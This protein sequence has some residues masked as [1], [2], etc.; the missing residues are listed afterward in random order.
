MA[1]PSYHSQPNAAFQP[2]KS[3]PKKPKRI[4]TPAKTTGMGRDQLKRPKTHTT[5]KV[6]KQA[7][8][9]PAYTPPGDKRPKPKV[10]SKI[11][12]WYKQNSKTGKISGKTPGW[13]RNGRGPVGK[14]AFTKANRPRG[15][16]SGGSGGGAGGGGGGAGGSTPP[17]S[18]GP[19]ASTAPSAAAA[20]ADDSKFWDDVFGP[21]QREIERQ[22]NLMLEQK[23]QSQAA[24]DSYGKWAEDKR[25]QTAGL[26]TTSQQEQQ[27]AYDTARQQ[28][29]QQIKSYVDMAR[30][31]TGAPPQG[32]DIAQA[33]GT[34][35]LADKAAANNAIG[36]VNADFL[37]S[38][39]ARMQQ[40]MADQQGVN[41]AFVKGTMLE[42][43]YA[44]GKASEALAR[45]A[46][47][48]EQAKGTAKL[49]KF[50]RDRQ[51]GLDR[52]TLDW[53]KSLQGGQLALEQQKVALS[54]QG[55]ALKAQIDAQKLNAQE[56]QRAIDNALA[57]RRISQDDARIMQATVN[58][59]AT[60]GNKNV[61]RAAKFMTWVTDTYPEFDGSDTRRQGH[62]IANA[63]K[64]ARALG[65][66]LDLAR[67]SVSAAFGP[68][69]DHHTVTK[70]WTQVYGKKKTPRRRR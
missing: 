68:R 37:K 66:P 52:E 64:R 28:S 56:R 27:K 15:A 49:D 1:L 69:A 59:G 35:V 18:T 46:A 44:W 32:G 48:V 26:L 19:Q 51:F 13:A 40:Y 33:T 6:T 41:N 47:D 58:A 53:T 4:K 10:G 16:G 7:K 67:Q 54:A 63:I 70:I 31:G 23:K 57:E 8:K 17:R 45:K 20:A 21:A 25:A 9:Q 65:L 60:Q 34:N 62:M 50:Y 61:E 30:G 14:G 38:D 36:M 39:A 5:T 42:Q 3:P 12:A 55:Q 2:K 11:P 43:D 29:D 22:R 24:W